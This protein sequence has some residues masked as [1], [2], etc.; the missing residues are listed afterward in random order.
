MKLFQNLLG[1]L[2]RPSLIKTELRQEDVS[3]DVKKIP[4]GKLFLVTCPEMV[5]Y[6][7]KGRSVATR[8]IR[9]EERV[10]LV[11][12]PY[13]PSS[14]PT[15]SEVVSC[16]KFIPPATEAQ[17]NYLRVLNVD[18]PPGLS[19]RDASCLISRA[20]GEIEDNEFIPVS[21]E[22]AKIAAK[23]GVYLSKFCIDEWALAAVWNKMNNSEKTEFFVFCLY[24]NLKGEK[25]YKLDESK[26]LPLFEE[27]RE[28]YENDE[29][30]LRYITVYYGS[31]LSV[32]K[33]FV[34]RNRGA[35]KVAYSFLKERG[36][37]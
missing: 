20:K 36:A 23:K 7:V 22:L 37:V 9:T 31:E 13:E 12:E 28:K 11:S 19:L 14:D 27:F 17:L 1:L 16:E 3:N 29:T 10:S 33:P 18:F 21:L 6:K 32:F 2:T 34:N 24:Q 4:D 26:A 15:F 35:Y 30:F 25:D 8:H 5:V